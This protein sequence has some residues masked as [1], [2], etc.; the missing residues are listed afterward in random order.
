MR[1]SVGGRGRGDG[2]GEEE[3]AAGSGVGTTGGRGAERAG[4]EV[5]V[6]RGEVKGVSATSVTHK[7]ELYLSVG[8][9]DSW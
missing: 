1:E 5:T 4:G 8:S 2:E 6:R 7:I 3:R 9:R